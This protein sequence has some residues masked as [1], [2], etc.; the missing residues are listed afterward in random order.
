MALEKLLDVAYCDS[1]GAMKA[2]SV[3]HPERLLGSI[4]L[5]PVLLPFSAVMAARAERVTYALC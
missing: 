1:W 5:Q 2:L 4:Y 3:L